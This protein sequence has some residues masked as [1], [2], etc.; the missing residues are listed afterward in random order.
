MADGPKSPRAVPRPAA[1]G[2]AGRPG[3]TGPL[4]GVAE[5]RFDAVASVPLRGVA[6]VRFGATGA[7]GPTGSSGPTGPGP[8]GPSGGSPP[9]AAPPRDITTA[10]AKPGPVLGPMR[11]VTSTTEKA[12]F[13]AVET[14]P[15]MPRA[16]AK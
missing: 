8:S 15:P 9:P 13:R 12:N 7:T 2:S 16:K 14:A 11:L 1:G 6:E 4:R 10:I 3:A 5:A